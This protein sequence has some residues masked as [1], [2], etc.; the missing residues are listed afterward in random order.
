MLPF[1]ARSIGVI[2]FGKIGIIQTFGI[3]VLLIIEFGSSLMATRKISRI[4]NSKKEL[5]VFIG[6]LLTSKLL[7]LPV[8]LLISSFS[9]FLVPL[10][11]ENILFLSL[12]VLGSIFQGLTPTW[13]FQGIEKMKSISIS[14]ILFRFLGFAVIILFVNTS[15]DAWVILASFAC[16]SL[17]ICIFLYYK[18]LSNIG[19][20]RLSSPVQSLQ[21]YKDSIHSF[22]STIIPVLNQNLNL[23][24]LTLYVNPIQI[25]YYYGANR[26][27]RAFNTLFGPI[28]QAFYPIITAS[29]KDKNSDSKLIKSYTVLILL[30]GFIFCL[31]SYTLAEQIILIFFG[32]DYFKSIK[33]LK[34]FS[35]VLP[36]TAISNSLGRQW[37]MA[38]NK[39]AFYSFV[40]A[41]SSFVS[42]LFFIT[43]IE[44]YGVKAVPIS[45]ILYELL[46]ISL[47]AVYLIKNVRK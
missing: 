41:L 38:S 7:T 30:I 18:L 16:S 44:T 14:K 25:G 31:L 35:I 33:V 46:T 11:R 26:I 36:L 6:K 40:Q 8:I 19:Y 23:I 34:L 27:Y 2:E 47:I 4:K 43:I 5:K 37:L 3:L 12:V 20:F 32:N 15:K 9:A 24:I 42:L 17:L 39:D 29:V 1:I 10:F 22:F 28:S 13:Y 21:I 45:L